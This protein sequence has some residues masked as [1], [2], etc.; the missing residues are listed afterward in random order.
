MALLSGAESVA[1]PLD[2]S[3]GAGQCDDV[4]AQWRGSECGVRLQEA[5]RT[6]DQSELL[7]AVDGLG[8]RT[9]RIVS[10]IADLGNDDGGAIAEHEIDFTLPATEVA[11]EDD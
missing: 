11:C 7:S 6:R 9:E 3:L 1:Y 8:R 2:P 5:S 10:P 4:E